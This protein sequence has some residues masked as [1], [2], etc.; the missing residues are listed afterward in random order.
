VTSTAAL[1]VAEVAPVPEPVRARPVPQGP[2]AAGGARAPSQHIAPPPPRPLPPP[3][4]AVSPEIA[5][6]GKQV[7][8]N[9]MCKGVELNLDGSSTPLAA[10]ASIKLSLADAWI[11]VS[12]AE[13]KA[14]GV[15]FEDYRT[16]DATAKQWT[17]VQLA[18]T[19]AYAIWTSLGEKNG[20]WTWEGTEISSAGTLQLRDY[21]QVSDKTIKIWGEGLMSGS[22]QK[23]YEATCTR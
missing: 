12:F 11:T 6:L 17:R 1:A 8:G 7:A 10:N 5:K 20:K 23:R 13:T 22:W 18:S 16:Y 4:P 3:Q 2:G 9:Y 19:S 14:G 15:K 21:E